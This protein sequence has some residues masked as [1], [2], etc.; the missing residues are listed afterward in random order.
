M[1]TLQLPSDPSGTF[2]DTNCPSKVNL[3]SVPRDELDSF[4]IG[5]GLHIQDGQVH[6]WNCP[7]VVR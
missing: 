3:S 6:S 1:Y 5:D 7:D 4:D 2:F